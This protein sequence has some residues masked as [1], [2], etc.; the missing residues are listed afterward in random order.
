MT[1][2]NHEKLEALSPEAKNAYVAAK[3]HILDALRE[4]D[5]FKGVSLNDKEKT[6]IYELLDETAFLMKSEENK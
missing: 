3:G 5:L 2:A 6:T 1:K 4:M